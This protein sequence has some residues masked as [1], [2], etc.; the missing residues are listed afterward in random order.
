MKKLLLITTILAITG[1]VAHADISFSGDARMGIS[2]TNGG[3]NF[4][5][6]S[7]MRVRFSGSGET[8]GGLKFGGNM[9]TT[10]A[11][12][13]SSTLAMQTL[14]IESATLGRLSIGD[15]DG[16]AQAAVTQFV[17]L[18]FN[19]TGAH[20]EFKFLTGGSTSK[21]N[22]L[23]YTYTK[24]PLAVSLSLGEVGAT[25]SSAATTWDDDRAVGVSYTTEFWKVAAG[26]ED[27]GVRSQ[28]IVS[29]SY[30]NGQAEVKVAY[31]AQDNDK[32]QYVVYGTYI[33]GA[34][35][36]SAFFRKDFADIT[37]QGV[38]VNYELGGG[39]ALSAG[40]AEP[41]NKDAVVSIGATMSF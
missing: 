37:Y 24:G 16:A 20:Q 41:S 3:K 38:G 27:D 23:I 8:D 33:L 17:A 34:S 30:G 18:G 7:R 28:S 2:S 22:D 19:D 10:Q 14:F 21:G 26:F 29:G 13:F 11:S 1:G 9:R 6:S 39:M 32:D 12:D 31:G 15:T 36:L 4:K 25:T 40:Y 35:T 5:S